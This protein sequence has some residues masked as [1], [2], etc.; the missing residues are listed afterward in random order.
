M[1]LK[2]SLSLEQFTMVF[3]AEVYAINASAADNT[4]RGYIR[5]S[6]TD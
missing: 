6:G 3:Q 2:L 1:S 5:K 4:E